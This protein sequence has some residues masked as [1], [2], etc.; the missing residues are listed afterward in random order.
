MQSKESYPYFSTLETLVKKGA[1]IPINLCEKE[2]L[3]N[4]LDSAKQWKERTAR[5]FLRKN[6]NH[7]LMEAL[8]YLNL[9]YF[10]TF[11]SSKIKYGIEI[12]IY[13]YIYIEN[14]SEILYF[15]VHVLI[16]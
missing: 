16:F 2:T 7:G 3:S 4:A 15:L 13:I 14:Y 6:W 5:T 1:A 11:C 12:H 9:N 10:L 8:R